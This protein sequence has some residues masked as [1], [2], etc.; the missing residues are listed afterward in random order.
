MVA[1][2]YTPSTWEAEAGGL[3]QAQGQPGLHSDFLFFLNF[4]FKTFFNDEN[5]NISKIE[6]SGKT[7]CSSLSC[8]TPWTWPDLP[9]GLVF[10]CWVSEHNLV[11]NGFV[12]GDVHRLPCGHEVVVVIN[13]HKG[14]GSLDDFLLARGSCHFSGTVVSSS[15]QGMAVRAV[16]GAII[17]DFHGDSFA[18]GVVSSQ[19]QHHFPGFHELAHSNSKQPAPNR[20]E[21]H[22]D[23]QTSQNYSARP[24]KPNQT[25]WHTGG[26]IYWD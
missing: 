22:S 4:S 25:M 10:Q 17:N 21:L 6:A 23:F 19:D 24:C 3:L 13:F 26:V 16:W 15:H 12:Q 7:I 8:T 14:L 18:S 11:D 20:K 2:D 1:H 9:P 5:K